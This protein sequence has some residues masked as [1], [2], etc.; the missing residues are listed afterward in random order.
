MSVSSAYTPGLVSVII[1]CYNQGKYLRDAIESVLQ[2]DYPHKEIIV[3]NDGS[4]DNSESVAL[5]YNEVVYLS[6]NNQGCSWA[7]NNG[8]ALSKGE[9]LIFLDAD[10]ILLPDVLGYQ[11]DLMKQHPKAAFVSGGHAH[12]DEHLNILKEVSSKVNKDFYKALVTG[13]YIGMHAAVI[14]RRFIFDEMLF[15]I[16]LRTGEDYDFYLNIASKYEVFNHEKPIAAYRFHGTNTSKDL[17]AMLEGVLKALEK[18]KPVLTTPELKE[19]Y[20]QGRFNWIYFYGEQ[21]YKHLLTNKSI[22]KKLKKEFI[23]NFWKYRPQFYIKYLLHKY[24][25]N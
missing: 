13:N 10:D 11:V 23:F 7:R 16:S 5:Q 1:P 9:Y 17:P 24:L 12:A 25:R 3:V 20:R 4:T 22:P 2:Q 15:D 14:Y 8:I 19:A 21:M 18:Q 6:Q